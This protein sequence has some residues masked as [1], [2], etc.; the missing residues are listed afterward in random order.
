MT[1]I[2]LRK[3]KLKIKVFQIRSSKASLLLSIMIKDFVLELLKF[4]GELNY[5]HLAVFS[6]LESTCLPVIIPVETIIIPMGYYA[7]L[8]QK[9]LP[10]LMLAAT[11][12]IVI[13]CVINY[14]FAYLLGRKFIYKYSKYLHINPDTLRKLEGKFLTHGRLL[15]FTGR[16]IPIPAFKHI[17]TIPAGM[18]K[19]PIKQFIFYNA[20]GGF[21]FSTGMLLI[22]YFFGS[23][24]KLVQTAL[25]NFMIV[26]LALLVL[27]IVTKIIIKIIIRSKKDRREMYAISR[28]TGIDIKLL[29]AEKRKQRHQYY[30]E[31]RNKHIKNA[32]IAMKK[33]NAYVKDKLN[34]GVKK[35]NKKYRNKK[36]TKYRI[37]SA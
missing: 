2:P 16:F 25:S 28:N 8:G 30:I 6:A 22:G 19:M 13:G 5:I 32:K 4:I 18:A 10:L 11:T 20:L 24:E 3:L 31:Q 17:I 1:K 27:Y 12:G 21:I 15:M 14:Y 9:S 26:C 33:T 36:H 37:P 23:S 34:S 35:V 7:F 29:K